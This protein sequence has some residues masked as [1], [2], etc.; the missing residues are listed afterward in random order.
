MKNFERLLAKRQ[1]CQ[2]SAHQN[3]P[4]YGI[5]LRNIKSLAVTL[6]N[7]KS[8]VITLRNIESAF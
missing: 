4:L 1:I 2:Y 7:F 3:F 5:T 8:A 6:R